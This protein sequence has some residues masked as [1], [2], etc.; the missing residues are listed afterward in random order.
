MSLSIIRTEIK[1]IILA[2]T[3]IGT[4]VYDYEVVSV[5]WQQYL[6][7]F[8]VDGRIKAFTIQNPTITPDEVTTS[9]DEDKFHF[10]IRCYYSVDGYGE[11]GKTLTDLMEDIRAAFR[12]KRDLNGKAEHCYSMGKNADEIRMFDQVLCHYG[13]LYLDVVEH[14]QWR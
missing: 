3:G 9:A 5:N 7:K 14:I 6:D 11:S 4:K 2:V 8:K 1:T 13:E 10:I 12:I